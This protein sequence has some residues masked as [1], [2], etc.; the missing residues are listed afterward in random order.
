MSSITEMVSERLVVP[1]VAILC[2]FQSI[3]HVNTALSCPYKVNT[4]EVKAF[5]FSWRPKENKHQ[6][7][8]FLFVSSPAQ[9]QD[10]G[11]C[12]LLL[13]DTSATTDRQAR[14]ISPLPGSS[15]VT[16]VTDIGAHLYAA[17]Q[18]SGQTMRSTGARQRKRTT[19]RPQRV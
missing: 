18:C 4:E 15:E 11:S 12:G 16:P 2:Y 10:S 9:L 5:R 17:V 13:K 6:R 19:V 1:T 3:S 8:P 14:L 7:Q